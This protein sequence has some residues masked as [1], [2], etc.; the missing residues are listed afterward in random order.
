MGLERGSLG[1]LGAEEETK[2]LGGLRGETR[3]LGG[4]RGEKLGDLRGLRGEN[5]GSEKNR[6]RDLGG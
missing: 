3:K 5:L 4:L 6:L 2:R 1:D